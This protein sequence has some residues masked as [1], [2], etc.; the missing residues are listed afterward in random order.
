MNGA[1]AALRGRARC[2]YVCERLAL[3]VPSVIASRDL[4]AWARENVDRGESAGPSE[5]V[6]HIDSDHRD[7][8]AKAGTLRSVC[9]KEPIPRR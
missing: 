6:G 2:A 8:R 4:T 5:N 7:C 9:Q 1:H 3:G